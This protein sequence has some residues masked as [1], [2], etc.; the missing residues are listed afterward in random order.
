MSHRYCYFSRKDEKGFAVMTAMMIILV[1][2]IVFAGALMRATFGFGEA[3]ISMPLLTLLPISLHTSISLI[4]L[5]GLT[6]AGM[7]IS[8]GW[9]H[10]ERSKL[11][12]MCIASALGL[13][14]G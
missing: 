10:I 12:W 3:V 6:V 13:P 9:R 7:T 5:V 4:G 11:I 14:V 8:S 1:V 2:V